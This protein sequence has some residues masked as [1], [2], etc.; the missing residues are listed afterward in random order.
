MKLL[1]ALLLALPLSAVAA[2]PS[3]APAKSS[4]GHGGGDV[5]SRNI[6]REAPEVV[7]LDLEARDYSPAE[8]KLLQELEQRRI[9]LSR[10]EK[11]IDLREQ[12]VDLAEQRLDDKIQ[13]M[14]D[15]Q[16]SLEGLLKNLSD[17]EEEE[18]M[19]LARIYSEMKPQAAA[20]VLNNLDN[21]IVYDLF[22]RMKSKDTAGIMEKMS[23]GKAR[24]ISEML[25]EKSELPSF[26]E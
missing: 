13:Q 1:I 10:R 16:T 5:P 11:A 8:I 2:T 3:H 14:S 26:G 22:R 25:A 15:L 20:D 9:E 23:P 4:G 21:A 19:R 6:A 7:D 12:L 18:L 17:K 24:I